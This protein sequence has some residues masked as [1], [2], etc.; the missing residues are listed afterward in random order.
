MNFVIEKIVF[1]GSYVGDRKSLPSIYK[2]ALL[3]IPVFFVVQYCNGDFS[4]YTIPVDGYH[5]QVLGV[6]I[7]N[8]LEGVPERILLKS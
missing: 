3:G 1:E 8:K 7:T 2:F 4:C 6:L 5:T